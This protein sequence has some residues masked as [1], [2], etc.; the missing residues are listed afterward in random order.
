MSYFF[1]HV[2]LLV[3]GESLE[4]FIN[5][6]ASRGIYLWDITRVGADKMLVRVRLSGVKPLRHIARGTGSRFK[7]STREGVPFIVGRMKKRK[8]LVIGAVTF[9]AVLYMLSSFVWFIDVEGNKN[10]TRQEVLKVAHQ[11]GLAKGV[12]KWNVD[13]AVVERAIK[14]QLPI[15][16]WAGVYINGTNARIEIVEKKLP[17][18]VD[19][20]N[21]THVVAEKAGLVKEILILSGQ[22]A[23]KEGDTVVPGQILISGEI[24]PEAKPEEMLPPTAEE[25]EPTPINMPTYV[26]AKGIVRARIWYEGYGEAPLVEEGKRASGEQIERVSIKIAGKEIILKGPKAVPYKEYKTELEVKTLPHWRNIVVPVEFNKVQ[27]LE[28]VNYREEYTRSEARKL[29]EQKA[30]ATVKE[31]LPKEA[32]ILEQRVERVETGQQEDLVRVKVFLETLEDIGEDKPFQ[33]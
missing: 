16:S 17:S 19:D 6:A 30:L 8:M 33:P 18:G 28:L 23:V 5:M 21:P 9:L 4:K 12:L 31:Q 32:K 25:M 24:L 13:P 27:Y 10:I 15:V 2:S 20:T 11:A 29:A 1:G 3:Q 26:H 22:A 7:I 14:D